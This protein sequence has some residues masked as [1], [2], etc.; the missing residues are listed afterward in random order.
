MPSGSIIILSLYLHGRLN[1][2][3]TS[4]NAQLSGPYMYDREVKCDG[5][6]VIVV[7]TQL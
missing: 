3:I 4:K 6:S 2:N 5:T 1:I 7:A